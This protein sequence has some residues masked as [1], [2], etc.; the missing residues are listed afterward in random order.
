MALK[1]FQIDRSDSY[2]SFAEDDGTANLTRDLAIVYNA[3]ISDVDRGSLYDHIKELRDYYNTFSLATHT[4][5]RRLA[6]I[7]HSGND[8]IFEETA[9]NRD[10]NASTDA[11]VGLE[12]DAGAIIG[13]DIGIL[14]DIL[15]G[16]I[17][18]RDFPR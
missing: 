16:W 4:G 17:V 9:T 2:G 14:T 13:A 1:R 11:H 18:E 8:G 3:S 6:M 12:I 15:L 7:M 5:N 10:L